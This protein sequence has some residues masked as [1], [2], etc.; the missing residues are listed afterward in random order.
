[1]I[2]MYLANFFIAATEITWTGLFQVA[3]LIAFV[4]IAWLGA[5]ITSKVKRI[6]TLEERLTKATEQVIDQKFNS[7]R[8]V[9]ELR[10][11]QVERGMELLA[12]RCSVLEAKD[13]ELTVNIVK[14]ISSLKDVVATKRDLQQLREEIKRHG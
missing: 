7:Q 2:V 12:Q 9:S 11:H 5:I 8:E 1:M 4:G 13:A 6:D 3:Q 14:E 10:L